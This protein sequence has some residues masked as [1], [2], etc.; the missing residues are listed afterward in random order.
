MKTYL[1]KILGKPSDYWVCWKCNG[2][3][4]YENEVC[5]GQ[6]QG[7]ECNGFKPTAMCLEGVEELELDVLN[8]VEKEIEFYRNLKNAN[9]LFCEDECEFDEDD[10]DDIEIYV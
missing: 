1:P 2:L 3:N 10:L 6:N 8:W 9:N 5:T 7:C 4:W